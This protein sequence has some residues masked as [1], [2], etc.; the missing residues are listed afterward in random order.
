MEGIFFILVGAALFT[1]SWYVLGLYS[2]GRTMGV[3]MG[4]LGL[5]TLGTVMFGA[6]LEAVLLTG[7]PD[8]EDTV[9]RAKDAVATMTMFKGLVVVW[10]IYALGAGAQGLW[11]FEDRAVGF[12]SAFVAVVSV[13]AFLYFAINLQNVYSDAVWLV[14]TGATL[15][16]SIL[17][18]ITF[19]Y[20]AFQWIVLRLVS[21]WF[22]LLGSVVVVALGL[23][24][25]GTDIA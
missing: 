16:L 25:I 17:A 24:M 21:G 14:I 23:V 8:I 15:T 7:D 6:S 3:L 19:F 18:S 12:Y 10:A 20:L 13:V 4:A 2:E 1:Q 22:I 5:L 11:E 9:A